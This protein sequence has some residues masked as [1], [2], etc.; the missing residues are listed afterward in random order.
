MAA[1]EVVASDGASA[2]ELEAEAE[3]LPM[4][5]GS[6]IAVGY[7]WGSVFLTLVGAS[8]GVTSVGL[9]AFASDAVPLLPWQWGLLLVLV[10]FFSYFEAYVGF[11]KSWA[12]WVVRRCLRLPRLIS[13]DVLS[14]LTLVLAPFYAMGFFRASNRRLLISLVLYPSIVLLIVGVKALPSPYHELVDLGVAFGIW[15]GTLS[16]LFYFIGAIWSG[17][18]P[19]DPDYAHVNPD[20]SEQHEPLLI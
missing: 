2:A 13:C 4:G 18:I 14:I 17:R 9:K 6:W 20:N 3:A 16:F 1:N 7:A 19:S 5:L 10:C 15:G 8:H 12:P 11:H